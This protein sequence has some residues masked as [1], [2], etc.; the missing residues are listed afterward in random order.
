MKVKTNAGKRTDRVVTE[1]ADGI[2]D[3]NDYN[4]TD[5]YLIVGEKKALLIDVGTGFG[6]LNGTVK[7][8]TDLPLIVAATH[9]HTDHL[10]GRGQ[11]PEIYVQKTDIT[12]FTRF[13]TSLP[14]RRFF[15]MTSR[16]NRE[17]TL[18]MSDLS[19]NEYRTRFIPL[20]KEGSFDL[21]GRVIGY[22]NLPGHTWGS[23]SL[24]DDKTH[25]YL[26]GDNICASPWLFL[27]HAAPVEVWLKSAREILSKTDD[28]KVYWSHEG[29]KLTAALIERVIGIGMEVLDK[30][31]RDTILPRIVFYPS[32]DRVNGSL[33]FRTSNVHGRRRK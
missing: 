19:V 8:L 2:Y 17:K 13:A 25:T 18:K 24:W 31:P 21:G 23:M 6:D 10:G 11:F 4:I 27:A 14:L 3:I 30:Y 9:S 16:S 7:K 26:A 20:E 33:V 5:L 22:K 32:N 1:I 12:R 28:Y 15:F 29:G